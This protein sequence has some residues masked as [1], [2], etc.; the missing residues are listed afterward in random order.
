MDEVGDLLFAHG[1]V[2]EAI[3]AYSTAL[4]LGGGGAN[5]LLEATRGLAYLSPP[6]RRLQTCA[7]LDFVARFRLYRH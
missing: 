7:L 5:P 6:P 2:G 1:S 4:K 3:Q